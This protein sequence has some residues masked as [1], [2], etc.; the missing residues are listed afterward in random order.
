MSPDTN[1]TR[2]PDT[3]GADVLTIR[4]VAAYL[5]LPVSTAYRLAE[6]RRLPGS[7]VG[8]QWRFHKGALDDWFRRQ[9]N[10]RRASILVADDEPRIR[11][12]FSSS[13]HAQHR[14][15]LTAASGEE[16]LAMARHTVFD[17]VILDLVMPGLS[18][19]ETFRE[20]RAIRPGLPVIIVTG[21]P[22]SDLMTQALAVGPFTVLPKPVDMKTLLQAVSVLV[23][24]STIP[25][26]A[27]TPIRSPVTVQEGGRR[28]APP[29]H[30]VIVQRR[31]EALYDRLCH[32]H[33]DTAFVVVDRR[34]GERRRG[35]AYEGTERRRHERRRAPTRSERAMWKESRYMVVDLAP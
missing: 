32:Q 4:D 18:G 16:A 26:E 13:L 3:V 31:H 12:L 25:R 9:A 35:E 23:R 15:V 20:L 5:K 34:T 11:E 8:R 27:R 33:R 28:M 24:R 30:L 2:R 22:D 1:S 21:Y 29:E 6:R 19:V 7:K 14:T 17:L 10:M